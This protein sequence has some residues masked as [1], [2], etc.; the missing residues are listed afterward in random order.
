[1]AFMIDGA[2]ADAKK[3]MQTIAARFGSEHFGVAGF[4][5]YIDFPYRL[6]QPLTDDLNAVQAA[7]DSLTLAYGGDAPEAYGRMMYESYADPSIGWRTN[8]WRYLV[9]FGDSYPH[10]PDAGRD[11]ILG[12]DDDL[13]LDN[14]LTHLKTNKITLIYVADPGIAG[15]TSLLSEWQEWTS[16]TAGITIQ[17]ANP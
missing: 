11:E 17:C 2:K 12:T 13:V 6:Y 4:S 15:D 1:M 14:V 10:D 7:I 5:D 9:I 16:T 8:A 3:L